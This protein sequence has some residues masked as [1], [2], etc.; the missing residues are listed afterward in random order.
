[1]PRNYPRIITEESPKISRFLDFRC[2][3][4]NDIFAN[5]VLRAN[6]YVMKRLFLLLTATS[7]LF[8]ACSPLFY[9]QIATLSSEN[10]ELKSDGTFAYEDAMV[11]IEYDFWSE[12]G[13]FSFLVTNNTDDNLYL[14]LGESYFVNNGYAH[15]Y[16]Q[17]RTY[18]YTSRTATASSTSASAAVSGSASVGAN[19]N[20]ASVYGG[21]V[22][23]GA[24]LSASKGYGA[25]KTYARASESGVSVEFAEQALVCIPAHSSKSFEEFSV[26]S[27]VFRECGFVRD[28]SKK[29]TSVREFTD[30]T[31]PRV[32]ENRLVF[33]LGDITLP[34][35]NVFYV[36][37]Y[38]NIAY[39]NATEY[40]KVENCDGTKRDVKV[41]TMSANNKFYIT[42]DKTDL[43]ST[44]GTANDRTKTSVVKR[45]GS[46]FDDGIYR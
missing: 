4:V 18:V 6:S 24:A 5:F 26:A 20:F 32:F 9:Q 35:T 41:H 34:I 10:V 46:K 7:W 16:Y 30:L 14:N 19:K 37:E 44:E 17:A 36:S 23:V 27:S 21:I 2:G 31:S 8:A 38:Q 40:V 11:T 22:N 28:P 33:Q 45:G 39:D 15:D 43:W 25:S 29:E 3:Y 1:M 13:K 12:E 42:Y